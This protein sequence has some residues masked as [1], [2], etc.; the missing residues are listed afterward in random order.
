MQCSLIC[1]YMNQYKWSSCHPSYW[2]I[3]SHYGDF[4]WWHGDETTPQ[5]FTRSRCYCWSIIIIMSWL[6]VSSQAFWRKKLQYSISSYLLDNSQLV[7]TK[8]NSQDHPRTKGHTHKAIRPCLYGNNHHSPACRLVLHRHKALTVSDVYCAPMVM[9]IR[10]CRAECRSM[11]LLCPY[12]YSLEMERVA[13]HYT[14]PCS[15]Y[16]ISVLEILKWKHT[17]TS[18]HKQY[19]YNSSIACSVGC[20]ETPLV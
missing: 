17:I 14:I 15:A 5:Q 13:M 1:Y 6:V 11:R 9:D 8:D 3:D 10:C 12:S 4:L 20:N 16:L 7:T 18:N 19:I 2:L